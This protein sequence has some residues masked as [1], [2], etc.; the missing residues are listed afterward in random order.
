MN[1]WFLEEL[2]T[3]LNE[4]FFARDPYFK[5]NKNLHELVD[6]ERGF[7][8]GSER[9]RECREALGRIAAFCR[10]R[11]APLLIAVS[12][13]VSQSLDADYRYAGIHER[14]LGW[15]R[16]LDVKT[17]DLLAAVRGRDSEEISVPNDGH[18][19]AEAHRLFALALL[20]EV[21]ALLKEK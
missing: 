21:E 10:D 14:V 11:G 8:P 16:E 1:S 3:E 13:D 17:I 19:N 4:T 18:P 20:P 6:V 2:K 7:E 9:A 12:P 15:A 5:S